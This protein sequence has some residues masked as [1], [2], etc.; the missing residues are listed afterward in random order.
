MSIKLR[1]FIRN[2]RNCRTAAEERA[3]IAKE[4][5]LIRNA[6]KEGDSHYRHRNVA[7]L[8]F[9]H[10]MG[11]PTH[12]GQMECLR[13]IASP[14]FAEKRI[15]YL[16]LNQFMDEDADLLMLVTNSIKNDLHHSS[17]YVNALGLTAL[18]NI[19][20]AEMCQTLAREVEALCMSQNPYI[21]RK[22]LVCAIRIVRK[23]ED[24]SERF[25]RI[26][27]S[28]FEEKNHGILLVGSSLVCSLIEADPVQS[29][30]ALAA[31]SP[32]LMA[33][34]KHITL[35]SGYSS[36]AEYD[37]A[38]I[39]DPFLQVKL[40]RTLKILHQNDAQPDDAVGDAIAQVVS[41][42]DS[43]RSPGCAVLLECATT[44]LGIKHDKTLFSL[45]VNILG[46]F[47]QNT[48][49][50]IRYVALS[51]LQRLVQLDAS[52]LQPHRTTI[53]N[54]LKDPDPPIRRRALEV[55]YSLVNDSTISTLFEELLSLLHKVP[56]T[57][58]VPYEDHE[59]YLDLMSKIVTAIQRYS[60]TRR[61]QIDAFIR[62]FSMASSFL[63]EDTLNSF[64]ILVSVTPELQYYTTM[65]LLAAAKAHMS[66]TVLLQ[67]T[68][69]TLGEYGHL[70]IDESNKSQ[71]CSLTPIQQVTPTEVIEF[72]R[73]C[74]N[75][76]LGDHASLWSCSSGGTSPTDMPGVLIGTS[77]LMECGT[78]SSGAGAT[79]GSTRTGVAELLLNTLIK[80]SSRFPG[81]QKPIEALLSY[82]DTH[83]NVELQ[84]RALEYRALL[85]PEW[86]PYRSNVFQ[87]I[88]CGL[89]EVEERPILA[90]MLARP[91][92]DVSLTDIFIPPPSSTPKSLVA[93]LTTPSAAA[94]NV[95][96]LDLGDLLD[97]PAEQQ[98]PAPTSNVFPSQQ[99]GVEDL[100]AGLFGGSSSSTAEPSSQ[101][102]VPAASTQ[103]AAVP[104]EPDFLSLL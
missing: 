57:A 18:G 10:M 32:Q 38:G 88:P 34:L 14:R 37:V 73:V 27:P 102:P 66:E 2:I 59:F 52:A 103:H 74:T 4:C 76:A 80:L 75:Q 48:D 63:P 82:Y 62:T 98:Q 22:A 28:L 77:P 54:C 1:D 11:Y 20:S 72:L 15:G 41:A 93:A 31:L 24:I 39:T 79:T 94:K 60:P 71:H 47:L 9:I 96:L 55:V 49:N 35:M 90:D 21:R 13:L 68:V 29:R 70:L 86:D 78:G 91:V 65:K 42:T 40:L 26:V 85:N 36:A 33:R 81:Y 25:L 7:K 100:L 45:C 23:V 30:A 95:D 64:I 51:C 50:N 67:A 97:P 69:W 53:V 58:H 19:G 16:G 17:Q 8:L 56:R 101:P 44:I 3:V 92:G 12:F 87:S 43:A 61:W 83:M 89:A 84:Q 99:A 6:F 46:K 5:A 104:S